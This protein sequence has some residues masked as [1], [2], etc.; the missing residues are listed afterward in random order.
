MLSRRFLLLFATILLIAPARAQEREIAIF[1]GGCFWCVEADFDLVEGVTDTVSG[2]TG[3]KGDNPT[4]ENH[5]LRG[6]RE[7]V[8]IEFDP[9]IVS[10]PELLDI[11]F[12]SVDPTDA[13]GQFCDRGHSYTTAI[14]VH[15]EGQ[16][17]AAEA[18]KADAQAELGQ[19][20]VTPVEAA[21]PFYPAEDYHQDYYL[22]NTIRYLFYRT[23]CGRDRRLDRVW[24]E[25]ARRG[26][27]H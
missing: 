14:Y 24:G 20:I 23:G 1:A 10:Y 5:A 15:D 2:Y 26:L 18:A 6:F 27:G 22:K 16:K 4:Y 19:H 7:A 11:F 17:M 21:G 9:A 12:H 3:G 8:R 25:T 13:D